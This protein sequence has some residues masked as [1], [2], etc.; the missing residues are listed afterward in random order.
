VSSRG[1]SGDSSS[2]IADED[3]AD[4]SMSTYDVNTHQVEKSISYVGREASATLIELDLGRTFPALDFFRVGG[5][6]HETLRIILETYVSYRPDIGYVQGM[7]FIASVL[8]LYVGE[9]DAFICFAN[10][11]NRP[12]L[13]TFFRMEMSG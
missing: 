13:M 7:S 2:S 9:L 11:L 5:P 8:L 6:F 12:V 10:I 4:P 1:D 3:R